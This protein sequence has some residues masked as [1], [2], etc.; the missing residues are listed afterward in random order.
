[1]QSLSFDWEA[2]G[3]EEKRALSAPLLSA[4]P[5]L[6]KQEMEEGGW[7][8]VDFETVPELVESRRV[9]L[10]AGKAY[11]PVREQLSMV[12]AGFAERLDKGLE[13]RTNY[14]FG[15][16]QHKKTLS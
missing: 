8:K 5:G 6:K 12:L 2:V 10:K 1:M 7:F 16:L 3:E 14:P 15:P 11:V 9:F 4:T 13:V